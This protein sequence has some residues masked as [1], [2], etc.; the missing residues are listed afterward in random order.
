MQPAR[1]TAA[2]PHGQTSPRNSMIAAIHI[3]FRQAR[4]DL[5]YATKDELREERLA[6]IN[7]VLRLKRQITSM[8]DCTDRQLGLVLDALKQFQPQLPGG[9]IKP[10][11][12]SDGGAEIIHLAS[13]EQVHTINL[14]FDFL[15]WGFDTRENFLK[16]RFK[17]SSPTMLSPKQ[18]N[19]SVM[20]LLTIAA[21]REIRNRGDVARV[22]R[23]MIRAEIPE[24]KSRL[25]IDRKQADEEQTDE[26]I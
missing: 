14:L 18:A 13:A 17:R 12:S 2:Q 16:K 8:R 7:N 21:S 5:R 19:S 20:I 23:A 3:K 24:L 4:P 26:Q 6:F 10:E 15:N 22:S 25:G 1:Q 9:S 11:Q